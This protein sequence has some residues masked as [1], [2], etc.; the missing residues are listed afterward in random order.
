MLPFEISK[1]VRGMT[2]NNVLTGARIVFNT[3][4]SCF[5]HLPN[6]I[7]TYPPTYLPS[8][9]PTYLYT[10]ALSLHQAMM[11]QVDEDIAIY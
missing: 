2:Q 7:P 3:L 4:A 8:H 10:Y 9:Q 1:G 11:M 6:Y 5:P